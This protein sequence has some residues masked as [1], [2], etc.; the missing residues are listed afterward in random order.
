M[1]VGQ[2]HLINK[3]CDDKEKRGIT[4]EWGQCMMGEC[5][6]YAKRDQG[7][8]ER[9]QIWLDLKDTEDFTLKMFKLLSA[10][11][12]SLPNLGFYPHPVMVQNLWQLFC[13]MAQ[14]ERL[15]KD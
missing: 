4:F 12:K 11:W 2:G 6:H 9:Y 1:V 10:A 7:P 8:S 13:S 5:T 14:L 3:M 15:L